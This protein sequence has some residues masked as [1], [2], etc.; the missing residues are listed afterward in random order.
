MATATIPTLAIPAAIPAEA[1]AP[2]TEAHKR[3][4]DPLSLTTCLHQ[5]AGIANPSYRISEPA[6]LLMNDFLALLTKKIVTSSDQIAKYGNLKTISH[7]ELEVAVG[8]VLPPELIPEANAYAIAALRRYDP[9][10][11]KPKAKRAPGEAASPAPSPTPASPSSSP[12]QEG[13]ARKKPTSRAKQ[14]AL[15]MAVSRVENLIRE[16]KQTERMADT[17]PI[18]LAGILEFLAHLL[19]TLAGNETQDAGMVTIKDRHLGLA[20]EKSPILRPLVNW[21]APV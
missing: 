1:A 10:F 3:Q 9:E 12:P 5:L 19:W 18:Y 11:D 21:I 20:V 17:A 7:K 4:T 13:A 15:T 16:Y 6:V 14:A 8:I 2:A